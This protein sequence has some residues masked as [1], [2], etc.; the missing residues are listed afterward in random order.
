[1]SFTNLEAAVVARRTSP[2]WIGAQ[3]V[4][5]ADAG[6]FTGEIS[7]KQ[8]K[9]CGAD[10]VLLGHAERR[11]LFGEND[12]QISLK[13]R[14]CTRHGL[15]VILCVG[16]PREIYQDGAGADFVERQLERDLARLDAPDELLVLYEPVWSIGEGGQPAEFGYVDRALEHIHRFLGRRYPKG[17]DDVPVMCLARRR[18]VD[19]PLPVFP[20][21]RSA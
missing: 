1:V 17:G 6:A 9:V 13:I 18:P 14:A 5:W 21:V 3:N 10:F 7:A 16:E 2:L 12:E 19:S 20:P 11:T 15:R 8:L 4:H